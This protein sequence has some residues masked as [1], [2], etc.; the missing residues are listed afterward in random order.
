MNIVVIDGDHLTLEEIYAV[1]VD[2]VPVE[3][4]PEAIQ[5]IEKSRKYVEQLVDEDTIV[6]GVTTGFGKF[7]NIKISHKDVLTLQEN[8]IMSHQTGVGEPFPED[9]VRAIMLLRVNTLAKGFSG[10]RPVS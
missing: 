8:L 9:V 1:A 3:I 5:K 2:N 10:I 6:Y 4:S 7:S